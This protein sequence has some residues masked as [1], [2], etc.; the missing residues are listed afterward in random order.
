[1]TKIEVSYLVT[2]TEEEPYRFTLGAEQLLGLTTSHL[3]NQILLH[4]TQFF[5]R[6]RGQTEEPRMSTTLFFQPEKID[7]RN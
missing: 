5:W 6:Q 3:P 2:D 4:I 1:M 7:G